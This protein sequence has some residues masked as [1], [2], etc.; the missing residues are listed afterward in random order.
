MSTGTVLDRILAQKT[1]DVAQARERVSIEELT[2]RLAD[3]PPVRD[4][5]DAL[6]RAPSM[7]LIAEVKRSSPSAGVIRAEFDPIAIAQAYVAAGAHCISVLTDETFFGGHLDYLRAIREFA[8]VPLL[9]KDFIID[10]HQV[11]E[12]RVAGADCI[13]LIAECLDDCRLRDLY[14]FASE[15]GMECLIE[16]YDVENVERVARL[17]PRLMGV[18]NRD[19]R[20]FVTD[21]DRTRQLSAGIPSTTLLVSESGLK[22]RADVETVKAAGARAILVGETL[23]RSND[24]AATVRELTA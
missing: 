8:T 17:E 18:N 4:F 3:A 10:R 9:R 22:T 6:Q 12:A 15:L 23:M 16:V 14:F 7:G 24:V 20:S 13:L 11:L 5:V 2:D 21:L 1:I 19:L